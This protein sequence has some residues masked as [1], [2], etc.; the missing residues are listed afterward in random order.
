MLFQAVSSISPSMAKGQDQR[1][2]PRCSEADEAVRK[3]NLVPGSPVPP[4][5]M[6]TEDSVFG[7]SV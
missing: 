2:G 4:V 7:V 5:F 3:S 1:I 6:N